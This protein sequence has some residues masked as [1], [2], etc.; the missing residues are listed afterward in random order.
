MIKI[1]NRKKEGLKKWATHLGNCTRANGIFVEGLEDLMEWSLE[2]GF[3]NGLCM[4][5]R[6]LFS[7]R[8]KR[9]EA[10]AQ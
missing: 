3:N 5:E 1:R 8:M 9:A 10:L 7:L 2:D 6:M 4:V